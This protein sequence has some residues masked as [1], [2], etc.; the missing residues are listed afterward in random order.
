MPRV[1]LSLLLVVSALAHAA[2]PA[3][4][5]I[6]HLTV[7]GHLERVDAAD[8]D[9]D[10]KLDLIAVVI[11]GDG[12][13]AERSLAIFWNQGKPFSATP[14][15][16]LPAA[17]DVCAFDLADVDGQKG[18]ELIEV[19]PAGLRTRSFVGRV[20]SATRPLV[21]ET[22]LFLRAPTDHLPRF[23]VVQS[24]GTRLPKALL[25]PGPGTLSVYAQADDRF[26]RRARLV[27][28]TK[29]EISLPRRDGPEHLSPGL[30][31]FSVTTRFPQVRV[32]DFNGDGRPDLALVAD[33]T[34]RGFV[35]TEDGFPTE[36]SFEHTFSVRGP[37]EGSDASVNMMLADV[38]GDGRVDALV[39]KN[40]SKGISSAK[41]TVSVFYATPEGF[42]AKADQIIETDGAAVAQV[43]LADITGDGQLDLL[44]PSMKIGL[45]SIIRILTSSSMKVD[46]HLHPMGDKKRF[47][48]KP[49]AARD[50]V[51]QL[52]LNE[53]NSD[54]QAVDMTGDFDGDGKTDLAF[55]VGRE[56][57]ALYRGGKAGE[58]FSA[59][60]MAT[61]AVR[62]FGHAL[63]VALDQGAKSDLVLWYPE[64]EG[65][66]HELA[67]VRPTPDGVGVPGSK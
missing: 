51:F 29:N 35:Q 22:T 39:T 20:A 56:E 53:N 36:A 48:A 34:V 24:L 19:S 52:S 62:A 1:S 55:G 46:F 45:F 64:T 7:D 67:V 31:T 17:A 12:D 59:E 66:Q 25:V 38:D 30:P 9:G 11:K 33:E 18:A 13:K 27:V 14:D 40:T 41:T 60:P 26:V 4:F 28:E 32:V 57:L 5:A 23:K 15:L 58:V 44:V 42:G 54:L 61:I 21:T 16:V 63:P 6:E 2:P 8:L 3:G 37:K 43:Q 49:T 65:H 47:A 10:G 50:L